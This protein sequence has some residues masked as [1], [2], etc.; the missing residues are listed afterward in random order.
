MAINPITKPY[1]PTKEQSNGAHSKGALLRPDAPDDGRYVSK[2]EY[3]ATYYDHADASYEW[4]DGYL[5]AK[6]LPNQIQFTLYRWF[7]IL[8]DQYLAVHQ[9]AK[10]IG[11]ET[12]FSL[13]VPDPKKPNR[14]KETVRK[15]D[16]AVVHNDN[17]IVLGDTERSYSGTCDLCI[18]ALSDSTKHEVDRDIKVKKVEYEFVGVQEY[19]ILDPS[20]THMHFYQRTATGKYIEITPDAEGV[21]HSV[22]LPGFRFRLRDLHQKPTL[23]ALALDKV[24]QGYVLLDYQAAVAHAEAEQKRAEAEQKRA[25]A[26]AAELTAAY[27]ELARLRGTTSSS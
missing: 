5:E 1:T 9:N 27:A 23:E 8:L 18:E 24:Y 14:L 10:M 13:T 6:P 26:L 22:V 16:I 4:N 20:N 12:G 3:W 7:L 17:P 2:E 15:P 21:I 19:Y 25:E 11:L